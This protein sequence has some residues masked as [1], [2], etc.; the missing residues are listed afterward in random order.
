L[1]LG[2]AGRSRREYPFLFRLNA[3]TSI[4]WTFSH[5]TSLYHEAQLKV[6]DHFLVRRHR[7]EHRMEHL[8]GQNLIIQLHKLFFSG[9]KSWHFPQLKVA[10][11]SRIGFIE[12]RRA[13]L[14]SFEL[15]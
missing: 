11:F 5:A 13:S 14:V 10:Q 7:I 3:N 6:P 9:D 1:D 4:W 12:P 8:L 15:A 2:D